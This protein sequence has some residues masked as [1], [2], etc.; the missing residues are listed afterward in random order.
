MP[1]DR[2]FIYLANKFWT[3]SAYRAFIF[4]MSISSDKTFSWVPTFWHCVLELGNWPT[5]WIHYY[6]S[7]ILTVSAQAL[8]FQISFSKWHDISM[9]TNRL[10]LVTLTLEFVLLFENFNLANNFWT[11]SASDFIFHMSI[12]WDKLFLLELNVLTLTYDLL[13]KKIDTGHNL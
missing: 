7:N 3:V 12:P 13:L 8:I 5:F 1:Q 4:H 11:V 2:K 9:G 6:T 10:N